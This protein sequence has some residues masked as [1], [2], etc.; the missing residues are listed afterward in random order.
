MAHYKEDESSKDGK[1]KERAGSHNSNCEAR[2]TM[3]E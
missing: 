2:N 1:D 3:M